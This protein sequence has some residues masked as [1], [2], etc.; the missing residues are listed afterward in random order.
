MWRLYLQLSAEGRQ[1][2][3]NE[4]M[5][6]L[7]DTKAEVLS[8]REH[9]AYYLVY[10]GTKPHARGRG[11]ARKLLQTMIERVRVD[12][13][14]VTR[15]E[16]APLRPQELTCHLPLQ[17]DSE[18]RPVYLESSSLANNAYYEKFGFVVKKE[19]FLKRGPAPVQLSIMVREPQPASRFTNVTAAGAAAATAGSGLKSKTVT[20]TVKKMV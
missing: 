4:L 1:R 14:L 15:G 10:L 5:P 6:L 18:N 16:I 9:D 11:Y 8:E 13:H 17:A 2:Y 12:E 19:I 3:F 20:A 7:H